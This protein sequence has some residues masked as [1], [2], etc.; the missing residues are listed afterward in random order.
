MPDTTLSGIPRA[1]GPVPETPQEDIRNALTIL[2][3]CEQWTRGFHGDVLE[4]S[5]RLDRAEYDSIVG[6][7]R[8][9]VEKLEGRTP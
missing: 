7:L 5:I 6:R 9:A 3:S 1:D 4:M 8:L 2:Y